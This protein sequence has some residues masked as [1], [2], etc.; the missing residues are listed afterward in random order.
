MNEYDRS[1]I[2]LLRAEMNGRFNEVVGKLDVANTRVDE[3]VLKDNDKETRLRSVENW[4]NALPLTTLL[5]IGTTALAV[6]GL[7]V[8]G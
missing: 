2:D 1:Q 7:F 6:V 8:K 5:F 4:K 3:L